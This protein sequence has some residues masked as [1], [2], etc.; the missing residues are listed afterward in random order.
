VTLCHDELVSA[1]DVPRFR[2][3]GVIANVTP[4]WNGGYFGG[5]D[6]TLGLPR[7]NRMYSVT[8]LLE[9][10]ATVTFSSD[11]TDHIE[12][13]TDRADPFL[14]LQIGHN[15]QEP[16]AG[17]DAKL[18]PPKNERLRLEDLVKGYTRSGAY[19]LRMEGK[20]GSIEVGK[21]A[22]L[23]VLDRNLFEVDRYE[24]HDLAPSAVLFEGRVVSGALP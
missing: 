19:Q 2:K 4:H 24:I 5:A 16:E 15:R 20:L 9:A 13:K 8:P 14:G 18:R 7:Y 22:D 21:Y 10:G 12:W 1:A 23:V 17:K 11:I 3:L 6:R